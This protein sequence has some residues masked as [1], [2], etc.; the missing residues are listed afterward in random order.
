MSKSYH[1]TILVTGGAG[2][3]GSAFLRLYVPKFPN[4]HFLNLDVLT[5][6]G[7][8]SKVI[9]IEN[10]ENYDFIH[11]DICNRKIIEELFDRYAIDYVI[12][13]AAESHVDNSI[14]SAHQ[15]L[16]TNI[17]GTHI[18]LDVS[19]AYWSRNSLLEESRFI[20]IST[21][22]V[23]GSL[24]FND[25][26]SVE[27][28]R[29][30][31]NSPYSASKASAELVARSY[32]ITFGLPVIVTRSSN[33]YGPFQNSEKLIPK[34]IRNALMNEKIPI[35]GNGSNI[36]DWIY[37]D[38]NCDAIFNVLMKG[39]IGETYNIGGGYEVSNNEIVELILNKL[40]KPISLKEY[41]V[42]RPGH[43]VRYSISNHKVR[44]LGWEISTTINSGI[45]NTISHYKAVSLENDND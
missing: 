44:H 29:L 30:L 19:K 28:D 41:V 25:N 18:L 34:I 15:F 14:D 13:F 45:N 32:F 4:W 17:I 22:E 21:D 26:S 2:F 3:I 42:D 38:D 12:N 40:R 23:Y 37:V 10:Y 36:R 43:D 35:Y 11:G 24:E 27:E 16:M 6:A 20:Q 9:S 33:N 31:P 1:K 39:E 7:D 5:Y 8:L